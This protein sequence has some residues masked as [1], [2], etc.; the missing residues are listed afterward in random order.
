M[1]RRAAGVR[2]LVAVVPVLVVTGV[3]VGLA[4]REQR[5]YTQARLELIAAAEA[6][7]VSL[8]LRRLAE[9][10]AVV[11]ERVVREPGPRDERFRT[12]ATASE[13]LVRFPSVVAIS[14]V[15]LVP[16]GELPRWSAETGVREL[17]ADA[18]DAELLL[19]RATEPAAALELVRGVD[20]GVLPGN[21][22]AA[23]D[24]VV[25]GVPRLSRVLDPVLTPE[26]ELGA[27]LHVPVPGPGPRPAVLT[28][29]LSGESFL[30]S[31]VPLPAATEV[32]IVEAV[33]P[34]APVV[35]AR[36]TVGPTPSREHPVATVP[37][38]PIAEGW[39][40][41]V[42]PLDGFLSPATAVLPALLA[43]VGVLLAAMAGAGA[44]LLTSREQHARQVAEQRTSELAATNTAL[45]RTNA[46][47]VEANRRLAA[48]QASR[49]HFLAA[50]S[51]DLRTPL[52]A[53]AGFTETL[54]RLPADPAGRSQLIEPI[55]RNVARLDAM[56]G[57]VLLLT[58]L[59]AGALVARPVPVGLRAAV[60]RVVGDHALDRHTPVGIEIDQHIEV[61]A[62]PRHLERIVANLVVNAVRHGA[63]PVELT[64]TAT[65][66]G[67]EVTLVVRDHGPG[68]APAD[69]DRVF[70][71]FERGSESHP[72]GG[73][74]LGL[75]LVRELVEQLGG[76]IT[77]EDAAPGARF[78]LRL[79]AAVDR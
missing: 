52:T 41:E 36:T 20:L 59:D 39:R 64:A 56:I 11:A 79:P 4:E 69:R 12:E 13:L 70:E 75:A 73:T 54:E 23:A 5:E 62:D 22:E 60:D 51:H 77:Y 8:E 71:R 3:L 28:V 46:E 33:D 16:R 38:G 9:V 18:G 63:P 78:V 24:A 65:A 48:A 72:S 30:A 35:V 6:A 61:L 76:T 66:G 31:L 1:S 57:D 44:H 15:E 67:R 55:R 7:D 53:I 25:R 68:I 26:G 21:L 29:V 43:V 19:V 34:D 74:G 58:G 10:T 42:R 49:S 45:T 37:L 32:R 50:V 40:L 14:Y 17:A 27:A 47:L 2:V